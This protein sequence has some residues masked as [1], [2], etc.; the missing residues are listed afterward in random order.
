MTATAGTLSE[1]DMILSISEQAINDQFLV[2]FNTPNPTDPDDDGDDIPNLIP[3][4]MKLGYLTRNKQGKI[5]PS[6]VGVTAEIDSPT[7]ELTKVGDGGVDYR[8]LRLT[9]HMTSGTLTYWDVSGEEP[10][11]DNLP[12]DGWTVSWVAQIGSRDIQ[13]IEEEAMHPNAKQAIQ[14]ALKEVAHE[15]YLV[16]SL[17]CLFESTR[18]ANS[19]K[20]TDENGIDVQSDTQ[21]GAFLNSLIIT[22]KNIDKTQYPYVLGYGVTQKIPHPVT[23]TPAFRPSK[24]IFSTTPSKED[25]G[26]QASL[27]FCMIN[28]NDHN[29]SDPLLDPQQNPSAGVFSPPYVYQ[30]RAKNLKCDG[31]FAASDALFFRQ[32]LEPTIVTPFDIGPQ[33]ANKNDCKLQSPT[34]TG[35]TGS[36]S[37]SRSSSWMGD[38]VEKGSWWQGYHDHRFS[39][40]SS[41]NIKYRSVLQDQPSGDIPAGRK[42]NLTIDVTGVVYNKLELRQ[43]TIFGHLDEGYVDATTNWDFQLVVTSA[44]TGK[45]SVTRQTW[46][47]PGTTTQGKHLTAWAWLDFVMD[48]FNGN[49]TGLLDTLLS[50]LGDLPPANF[51]GVDS[52]LSS[53]STAIVMPAGDVYTYLG[54]DC[55]DSGNLFSHI[56]YKTI[57]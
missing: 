19:F 30:T 31:V 49:I 4:V 45:W 43:P 52:Q 11:L 41:V 15:D 39:G 55:D 8:S 1:Y 6:K 38:W 13:D 12:V 10:E 54:L 9:I 35:G 24:F 21:A 5:V 20:L 47:V 27:N 51:D 50:Q 53:I 18:V 2:L 42:R 3:N 26:S 17:F 23:G 44:E 34:I 36:N 22:Y 16:S 57:L 37:A 7:V 48:L 56:K 25:D 32:W 14:D 28:A 40:N 33:M 29:L 46:N